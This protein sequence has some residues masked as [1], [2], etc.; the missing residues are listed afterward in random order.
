[1]KKN[2]RMLLS[3]YGHF[4]QL[5]FTV[6][7]LSVWILK[8]NFSQLILSVLLYYDFSKYLTDVNNTQA[9]LQFQSCMIH[10][11][12]WTGTKKIGPGIFKVLI[13]IIPPPAPQK[14]KQMILTSSFWMV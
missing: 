3:E 12:G 2:T 5:F 14:T 10:V 4:L 13:S 1:M 11:Q 8:H 6:Y 9:F 7:I